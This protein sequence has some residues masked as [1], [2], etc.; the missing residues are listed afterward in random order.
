MARVSRVLPHLTEAEVKE[1]MRT[2][3]DFRRQQKW[4][5]VYNALVE[6]RTAAEIAKHTGTSVRNVHQV[7]SEYNRHGAS[8][9][10]TPGAGGRR[11]SYMTLEQEKAFLAQLEP[12]ARR[13][14]LTTK[15][16]IKQAFEQQVGH[17][18]HKSTIYR[19]LERHQWH[20]LKPRPRH[21]L[22]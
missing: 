15:A 6:P 8:A 16:E 21:P 2:A 18:V 11:T 10:E 20:K 5:I 1:K 4:W 3:S 22:I 14:E 17:Q 7:I 13:G 12:K 9:F 19:L